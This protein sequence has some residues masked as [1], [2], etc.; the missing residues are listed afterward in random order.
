MIKTLIAALLFTAGFSCLALPL[1]AVIAQ[2]GA[3]LT[4]K[5][6]EWKQKC[7]N[8]E[9]GSK[10]WYACYPKRV[11][12]SGE[13]GKFVVGINEELDGLGKPGPDEEKRISDRRKLMEFEL[14]YALHN[15]KCL[16]VNSAQC[17]E[18]ES[19]LSEEGKLWS[20]DL[21]WWSSLRQ[22]DEHGKPIPNKD[23]DH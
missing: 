10:L 11:E 16:G 17:S 7:G 22:L 13:W 18:E 6:A 12:L 3:K 15:I 20:N 4:K 2:E 8:V 21:A 5:T 9:T 1:S 14:S 19:R 23:L